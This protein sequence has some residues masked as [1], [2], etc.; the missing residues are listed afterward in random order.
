[1]NNVCELILKT[2]QVHA[3]EEKDLSPR[4]SSLDLANISIKNENQT[5]KPSVETAEF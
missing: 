2:F 4:N 1:M 5:D 3:D